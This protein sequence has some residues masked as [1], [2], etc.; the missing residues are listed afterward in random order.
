M[1]DGPFNVADVV[2]TYVAENLPVSNFDTLT[3]TIKSITAETL[4]DLAR[5]YFKSENMWEVIV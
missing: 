5:K 3:Q 2:K 4:R 1:L